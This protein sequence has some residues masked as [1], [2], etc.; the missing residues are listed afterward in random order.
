MK[1]SGI[2]LTALISL[3]VICLVL[4]RTYK[5]GKTKPYKEPE[6]LYWKVIAN[7]RTNGEWIKKELL[8]A[9]DPYETSELHFMAEALVEKYMLAMHY[10]T[11][12]GYWI[13]EISPITEDQYQNLRK[14]LFVTL[15]GYGYE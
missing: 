6:P 11:V 14:D 5:G 10:Q 15:H 7:I 13:E 4:I 12:N 8:L 9:S 2:L 1:P 3:V